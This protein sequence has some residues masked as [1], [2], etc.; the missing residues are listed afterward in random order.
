MPSHTGYLGRSYSCLDLWPWRGIVGAWLDWPE[1]WC[2]GGRTT[3]LR[4][5]ATAGRRHAGGLGR[6]LSPGGNRR[7]RT[8]FSQGDYAAYLELMAEWCGQHGVDV[9]AQKPD[10]EPAGFAKATPP[11]AC[12]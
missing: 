5:W 2:R 11:H 7:Q 8:F 10:A 1:W 12:I 9:W 6:E 3:R 4:L